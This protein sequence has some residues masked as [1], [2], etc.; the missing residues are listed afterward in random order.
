MSGE[1]SVKL[2]TREWLILRNSQ[3]VS[4]RF[5]VLSL[6]EDARQSVNSDTVWPREAIAGSDQVLNVDVC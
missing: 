1:L 2:G 5:D 4:E 6:G 3:G